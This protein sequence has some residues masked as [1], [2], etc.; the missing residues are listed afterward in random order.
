MDY[1][2]H[3]SIA[4]IAIVAVKASGCGP[5]EVAFSP[6]KVPEGGRAVA[7]SVN[8]SNPNNIVVA[9]ESGGLFRTFDGGKTFQHLDNFPTLFAIDVTISSLDGNTIIATARDDFRTVSGAGIWRSTDGGVSWNRPAG[10]PPNCGRRFPIPNSPPPRV[11]ARGISHMPLTRTFYVATDCGLAVSNDNG[12]SF[13]TTALNPNNKPLYSVLV[14]NRSTGVASDDTNVWFIN[15]GQWTKSLG[16]P[17]SGG[18][19]GAHQFASPW[20]AAPNI[21]YHAGR[22]HHLW[23]STTSGGAWRPMVSY[24]DTITTDP[25]LGSACGNR[26]P[27]V[28][29]GRGLDQDPTHLDV[30]FGDGT[31]LWRQA[32]TVVVPNGPITDWR[33]MNL[34]HPDPADLAFT[35]GY[36]LPLMLATDGGV[37]L[38]TDKGKTWKTTGTKGSGF[39]ALQ[40]GEMTGRLVTK[41]SSHLDLYYGTQDNNLRSSRDAGATWPGVIGGE[42]AFIQVDKTQSADG[43]ETGRTGGDNILFDMKPHFSNQGKFKNAPNSS[44]ETGTAFAP[45]Q[46]TGQSYLQPVKDTINGGTQYWLTGNRGARWEFSFQ[47]GGLHVGPV[48]FAGDLNDPVAYI[49]VEQGSGV[50]LIRASNLGAVPALRRADSTGIG[51]IAFFRTAQARYAVVGVDPQNSDHL[52][53]QDLSGTAMASSDG[54]ISWF[55][56]PV[57][58]SVATDNNKFLMVRDNQPFITTIGWDPTNSC[59][60]LVGTMQNGVMRSADGGRTW[61]QVAGSKFATIVSS[62]YFPP[63]GP[64]WMSAYGR[65]LWKIN[66]DRSVPDR[67]CPFP[68]PTAPTQPPRPV[69]PSPLP[70]PL[71]M[72]QSLPGEAV[73]VLGYNFSPRGPVTLVLEGDTVAKDIRVAGNGRFSYRIMRLRK[74]PGWLTLTAEQLRAVVAKTEVQVAAKD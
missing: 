57:L 40:I 64:I 62:F 20:W 59:H 67:G 68:E 36:D 2:R 32:T 39:M 33:K 66:V 56:L 51:T 21:F 11:V 69:P 42:G 49:A 4:L 12:A 47:L 54:G 8:Q 22:D 34:D 61:R 37:H 38:T 13:T 46:L 14:I 41:N 58:D 6:P 43:P 52:I 31:D 71:L 9:T 18:D 45:F 24:C 48:L 10:W 23:V 1:P 53:A 3:L 17:D 35:P 16:G 73:Q 28:R 30:Y 60:I 27:F 72:T 26:E 65:G 15:N 25:T 74:Q 7:I 44:T 50:M 29:V 19:L 55:A 5:S 70:I 63:N